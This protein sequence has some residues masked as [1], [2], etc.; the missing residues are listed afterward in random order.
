MIGR[1]MDFLSGQ[2][3]P[4]TQH[5]GPDDDLHMAVAALLIEA[6]HMDSDF[7]AAERAVIERVLENRFELS[8]GQVEE[9]VAAAEQKVKDATQL[10]PFTR[11]ICQ[12]LP[13]EARGAVAV[14]L[15][16][17]NAPRNRPPVTR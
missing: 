12:S 5:S 9:L 3:V 7:S 4:S 2:I 1:L 8:R 17:K 14:S 15:A 13:P 16:M 10:H 6:A 11:Q